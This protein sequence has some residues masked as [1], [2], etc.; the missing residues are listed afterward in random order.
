MATFNP[1]DYKQ[2]C[3]FHILFCTNYYWQNDL[4]PFS[5]TKQF[6][7]V[8]FENFLTGARHA[9]SSKNR[10]NTRLA[11]TGRFSL[12]HFFLVGKLCACGEDFCLVVK[13]VV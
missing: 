8:D 13:C 2:K 3:D 10:Q 12:V 9:F 5:E 4:I 11:R 7:V 6:V 1:Y